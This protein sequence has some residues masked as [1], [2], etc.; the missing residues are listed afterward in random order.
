MSACC[1]RHGQEEFFDER[2]A[3]RSAERYRRRGADAM[4]R[5]LA[6]RAGAQGVEGA[7]VLEI[8]GG[9]GQV[10]FELLERG[11]ARGEVVE[12]LPSYEPFVG[13]L[14]DERGLGERV[15]FRTADL[16]ADPAAGVPA[17]LVVLAKSD[18]V[19]AA[20]LADIERRLSAVLRPTSA[21]ARPDPA[22]QPDSWYY[23]GDRHA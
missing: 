3:R 13:R 16:V 5:S 6:R 19:P 1:A 18:L 22:A 9:I 15:A 20:A 17:D 14:A 2:A 12:L 23:R 21:V 7:S 11:A 4:A 10:M 8:G